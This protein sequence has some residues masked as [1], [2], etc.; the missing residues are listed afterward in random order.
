MDKVRK[1]VLRSQRFINLPHGIFQKFLENVLQWCRNVR[2]DS[3][4]VAVNDKAWSYA[5]SVFTHLS[6]KEKL[7]SLKKPSTIIIILEWFLSSVEK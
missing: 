3:F 7:T 5:I 2:K 6:A 1:N 4:C